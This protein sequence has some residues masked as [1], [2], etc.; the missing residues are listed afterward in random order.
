M[1]N[2][3]LNTPDYDIKQMVDVY[4]PSEDTFLFIDALEADLAFIQARKPTYMLEIGS[5]NG[6]ITTALGSHLSLTC[7]TTDIN[8]KACNA[9]RNTGLLN[10]VQVEPVCM[11]LASHF[12]PFL[13]DILIFNPPYV[14]TDSEE[15]IGTGLSRAWA[16][17][18]D[19]RE[20][21]DKLLP[22]MK[23]ILSESG[24]FYLLL[25]KE[26]KPDE[27]AAILEKF[28]F[29]H[30]IIKEKKI[31]GEYLYIVRFIKKQT[32]KP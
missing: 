21:I 10:K 28:G 23:N 27:V 20:I 5:G 3:T 24:I 8:I 18:I 26:N 17:G 6:V 11:D 12:R 14:L 32:S 16:G 22:Q 4:E 19:G 13:F 7:F 1:N 30:K 2:F 29:Q 15:I 9:T 31:L 25:L